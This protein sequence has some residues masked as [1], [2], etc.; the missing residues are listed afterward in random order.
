MSG[1]LEI[2]VD[3][4]ES[5]VNAVEG[6]AHQLEVCSALS[7]GGL[8]PSIGLVRRL[9]VS[10]PQMPL[11][12][13]IRPR[14]GDFIYTGD[15]IDV[16]LEDLRAMKSIGVAGFVFGVLKQI[17]SKGELDESNCSRL[18]QAARPRHCTLHRAFDL[19]K[20]WKTALEQAVKLG[21][22][23]ILTSGQAETALD[24]ARRLKKIKEAAED[25]VQIMA[26]CGVNSK[27][28]PILMPAIGC[29]CYHGSASVKV[30]SKVANNRL[31][32]G[33]LDT[34][35]QR[36]TSKEEVL[37]MVELL[38]DFFGTTPS[39]KPYY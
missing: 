7:S 19:V 25:R 30:E 5:A 2:C 31:K 18:I 13:M 20:D 24:G 3:S 4:Y 34:D 15:E 1:R 17:F 35:E 29:R 11:F 16:M 14:S 38:K 12:V 23:A 37:T 9:R 27:T 22:K 26:G 28:L 33:A 36:I 21:F 6:G 10:F 32:M 8:T 39:L